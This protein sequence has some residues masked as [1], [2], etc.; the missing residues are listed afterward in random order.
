MTTSTENVRETVLKRPYSSVVL[1]VRMRSE[2]DAAA[3]RRADAIFNRLLDIRIAAAVMAHREHQARRSM[4]GL[5]DGVLR[6]YR[7]RKGD[8]AKIRTADRLR[9][10]EE[11]TYHPTDREWRNRLTATD[12]RAAALAELGID[13]THPDVYAWWYGLDDLTRMGVFRECID[14]RLDE[15]GQEK[16]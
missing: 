8:R 16:R 7:A 15:I 12:E 6:R 1:D 14:A 3:R 11:E 5:M 13:I 9:E 2:E 4:H 10:I